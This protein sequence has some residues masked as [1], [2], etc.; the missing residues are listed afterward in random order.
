[1]WRETSWSCCR[2]T[3]TTTKNV[4]FI[5]CLMISKLWFIFV[6]VCHQWNRR[7]SSELIVRS[8][9]KPKTISIGLQLGFLSWNL[10]FF[11]IAVQVFDKPSALSVEWLKQLGVTWGTP[12]Q[13]SACCM[14]SLA[15]STGWLGS[16][17]SQSGHRPEGS[18]ETQF[19][20][21]LL[22]TQFLSFV[23]FFS[24]CCHGD[25][26]ISTQAKTNFPKWSYSE[27]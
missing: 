12:S 23:A 11:P 4:Q 19:Y 17:I 18:M 8:S 15:F 14:A 20:I 9:Y 3:T 16:H 24:Y 26:I 25:I 22:R 1:M 10:H 27:T 13:S 5:I 21:N 6:R 2:S 7:N